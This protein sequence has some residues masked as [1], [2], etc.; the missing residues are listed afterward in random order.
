MRWVRNWPRL[1]IRSGW[2]KRCRMGWNGGEWDYWLRERNHPA[3]LLML[4]R[5]PYMLY[6]LV[7]V[8]RAYGRSLPANRGELFDAFVETLLVR[9]R[10][11]EL[12]KQTNSVVRRLEG[13]V[14]LNNLTA[15]AYAMQQQRPRAEEA[16]EA[17]TA[18][19]PATV[20]Y[21]LN[22]YQRY[23]AASANLLTLG[24]EV[25]FAHQ[26]LQE[27]FVARAM[28]ERFFGGD[29]TQKLPAE[30]IWLPDN[31]W[32]PT[33]WEE[34]TILLAG[35]YSDDCTP[36]LDWVGAAN[37]EVAARCFV[38]S[39]AHT[40]ETTKE[41]LRDL[42]LPRLTDLQRDPSPQ[43]RA[44]VGRALG[45]VTL[46]DG[47]PLDKRR[48]VATVV[49]DGVSIPDIVWGEEVPA[50]RYTLGGDKDAYRSFEKKQVVIDHPYQLARYPVTYAQF[51]CFVEAAD[52][53]DPRWWQGMPAEDEAT[54][55]WCA[56]ELPSLATIRARR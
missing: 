46:A 20:A 6:M 45:L 36:V 41:R 24:D 1:L 12:D 39:G 26:L 28:R 19:P 5:N 51:Q 33:N 7:D 4:A 21:Y 47:T 25:R 27:Y 29:K 40:P 55:Y 23:Q 53:A 42:W 48:G 38:E 9:E 34:A 54:V 16:A 56:A 44:A 18:L 13:I 37:P 50:G 35:L 49:R 10:L 14:L 31:W 43:A 15:L 30:E 3:S 22:E 8:Y 11:F 2:P 32:A 17:L 52:F